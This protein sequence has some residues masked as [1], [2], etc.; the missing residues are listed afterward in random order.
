MSGPS[1]YTAKQAATAIVTA[2]RFFDLWPDE[3]ATQTPG[4]G[5]ATGEIYPARRAIVC[6]LAEINDRPG[7]LIG[8]GL[9]W[10]STPKAAASA[11]WRMDRDMKRNDRAIETIAAMV[12]KACKGDAESLAPLPG[13]KPV[14]PGAAN[15]GPGADGAGGIARDAGAPSR[16]SS[17]PSPADKAFRKRL[18]PPP[19][20]R[21]VDY[22]RMTPDQIAEHEHCEALL[23]AADK[24]SAMAPGFVR[25]AKDSFGA[26]RGAG[27]P[28]ALSRASLNQ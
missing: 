22:A 14:P 7:E 4:K 13:K 12:R 25:L 6:A 21:A 17:G 8:A 23:A 24:S 11:L 28:G 18:A 9:G 19:D 20:R 1:L 2:A 5:V 15:G 26:K 27:G 10:W 3:L 16:L